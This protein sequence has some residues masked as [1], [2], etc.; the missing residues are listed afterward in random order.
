[1]LVAAAVCPHPPLLVPEAT[2]ASGTPGTPGAS[3]ASA[4]PAAE[5]EELDRL[6]AACDAV[7]AVLLASRPDLLVIVG[8]A[9]RAADYPPEAAGGLRAYGVPFSVGSGEQVLPLSLTIGRW[10]LDRAGGAA[11]PAAPA[12]ATPA[13]PASATPAVLLRAVAFDAPPG[14]CV[15]LGARTSVLAERV[16][17]L[18]MGD[19]PGRRARGAPDKPDDDADRF[20]AEVVKALADADTETLAA[21]DP[22]RAQVLFAAG[23]AAWQ[24]LAGA[25]KPAAVLAG[26]AKPAATDG[27][28]YY[29][30]APFAVSYY[31]AS[32][33]AR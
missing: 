13:A 5:A 10:L 3:A 6:R 12:S 2:G 29:A 27:A 21:L 28:V 32:W 4:A 17:M 18:V 25:T 1:M 24:V 26:A 9:A 30:A 19:G 33:R 14:D 11:T 16:A 20:D 31:V 7:V 15:G 8:G 23:R 22:A